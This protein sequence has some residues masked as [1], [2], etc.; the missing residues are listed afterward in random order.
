MTTSKTAGCCGW[1]KSITSNTTGC[2]VQRACVDERL[3][4]KCIEYHN[5]QWFEFTP[6][7]SGRY[8]HQYRRARNAAMC[9]ACSWSF[10]PGSPASRLLTGC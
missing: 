7:V 8:F 9:A 4:G 2:T 3:T 5:D 1:R 6:K 10:S